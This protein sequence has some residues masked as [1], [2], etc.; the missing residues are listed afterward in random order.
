MTEVYNSISE[1]FTSNVDGTLA[2]VMLAAFAMVIGAWL[3]YRK[4]GDATKPVLMII[5]A[6]VAVINVA[7]WTVPT[8]D[9]SAPIDQLNTA[10]AR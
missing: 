1:F 10:E 5:L 6:I 7:I 9:G 8:S 4:S 3:L 2:F